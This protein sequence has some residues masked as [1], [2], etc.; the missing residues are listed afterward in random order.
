MRDQFVMS[1]WILGSAAVILIVMCF[2]PSP[3]EYAGRVYEWNLTRSP[4][5]RKYEGRRRYVDES[6]GSQEPADPDDSEPDSPAEEVG[7]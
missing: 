4:R 1:A 5:N 3:V 2:L 6:R 7:Q